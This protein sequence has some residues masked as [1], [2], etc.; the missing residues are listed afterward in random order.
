MEEDDDEDDDDDTSK[1][2]KL[3][4][5]YIGDLIVLLSEIF[6]ISITE[7]YQP[8]QTQVLALLSH[9]ANVLEEKFAPHYNTFMPGLMKLLEVIPSETDSQK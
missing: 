4:E 1:K 5:I 8:L 7:N 9:I 3:L 6:N 2:S